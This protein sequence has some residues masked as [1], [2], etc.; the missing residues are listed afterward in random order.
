M[1]S[2]SNSEQ[3]IIEIEVSQYL[4]LNSNKTL[5]YCHKNRHIGQWDRIKDSEISPGNSNY[6]SLDKGTKN[7][8]WGEKVSLTR[9][10]GKVDIYM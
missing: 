3:K 4:T 9:V 1:T 8:S 2:Q 10:L 5:W 6:L 7:I